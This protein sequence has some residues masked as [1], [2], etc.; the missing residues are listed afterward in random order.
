MNEQQW[1][2]GSVQRRM[3]DRD[4]TLKDLEQAAAMHAQVQSDPDTRRALAEYDALRH[5]L[6]PTADED[7]PDPFD[8][9]PQ[10]GW[11]DF[12]Q[13]FSRFARTVNRPGASRFSRVW[14]LA[15]ALALAAGAGLVG[16]HLAPQ[17]D[18][19]SLAHLPQDRTAHVYLPDRVDENIHAFSE[20]SAVFDQQAGW[21]SFAN[22]RS[23]MGVANVA[24]PDSSRLLMLRLS[25]AHAGEMISQADVVIVPGQRAVLELPLNDGRLLHY[26]LHVSDQSPARL[27]LWAELEGPGGSSE[28]LAALA[29]NL[30]LQSGQV[31]QAG[32]MVT[33][34]G[35]YELTLG[36]REA[37]RQA[38]PGGM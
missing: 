16:Y 30:K 15:A 26:T 14:Q 36:F 37:K 34:S 25:L 38:D 11:A 19:P 12:D 33:E 31:V 24:M 17:H 20:I 32:S 21:V 28:T 3:L 8:A 4:W 1:D 22:G 7:A 35:G 10:G 29:T 27:G 13:R 9:Q 5:T 2:A 23:D 18:E 6:A